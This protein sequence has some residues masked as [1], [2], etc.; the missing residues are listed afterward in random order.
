MLDEDRFRV[1]HNNIVAHHIGLTG[2]AFY[3]Y[4]YKFLASYRGNYG[5]KSGT[6]KP[7]ERIISIYLDANVWQRYIDINVQ[8]GADLRSSESSNA[9]IGLRVSKSF[10]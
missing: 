9:G 10:L 7:I 6:S 5:A 4:P 1:A 3:E 2:T 8:I